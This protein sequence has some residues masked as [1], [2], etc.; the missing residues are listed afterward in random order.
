M[1]DMDGYQATIQLRLSEG[2]AR[3]TPVIAMTA[4][5]TRDDREKC[6]AAGM[7]DYVS[8]PFRLQS[9]A[10]TLQRWAPAAHDPARPRRPV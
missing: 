7:D 10:D 1:P 6:L 3:H 2:S 4:H 9:L 8:K 5:A